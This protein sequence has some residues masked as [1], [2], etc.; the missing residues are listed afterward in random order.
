[1]PKLTIDEF[2]KKLPSSVIKNG[3]IISI[4]GDL[5]DKLKVSKY[6]LSI[7]FK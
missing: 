4:R 1:M 6:K 7:S 2:L 5:E 3:N